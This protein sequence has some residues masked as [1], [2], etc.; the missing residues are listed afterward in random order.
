M[1]LDKWLWAARFYKT[2]SLAQQ[3]IEAGRVRLAG[4]RGRVRLAERL[5]A[6]QDL[7]QLRQLGH[8]PLLHALEQRRKAGC[9]LANERRAGKHEGCVELHEAGTGANFCIRIVRARD[10]SDGQR[11]I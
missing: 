8:H 2:R 3:A 1:R 4:E 6:L 9:D 11:G 5:D 10:A 7:L